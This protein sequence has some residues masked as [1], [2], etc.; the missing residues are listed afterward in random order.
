MKK[1]KAFTVL[2]LLVTIL[3]ISIVV[4][5]V[6]SFSMKTTVRMKL[7]ATAREVTSGIYMIKAEA[8]KR[9]LTIRMRFD[10]D[11]YVYRYWDT[12]NTA[13]APFTDNLHLMDPQNLRVPKDVS[14]ITP[15]DFAF[16]PRGYVVYPTGADQFKMV[17]TPQLVQLESKGS[18]GIDNI[19]IKILP[20]GGIS[21]TKEFK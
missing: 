11:N 15:P 12:A 13:W 7:R 4:T 3:L 8:A 10:A 5:L 18:K 9:N 21:V 14:V 1:N 16:N 17:T 19:T 2:E 20:L 6:V